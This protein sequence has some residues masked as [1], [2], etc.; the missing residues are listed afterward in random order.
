MPAR[1]LPS[2]RS[3]IS[4]LKASSIALPALRRKLVVGWSD[5]HLRQRAFYS[6][7]PTTFED[8]D[9]FMLTMAN[10]G[11]ARPCLLRVLQACRPVNGSLQ[12][13]IRPILHPSRIQITA[14]YA[15]VAEVGVSQQPQKKKSKKGKPPR[16]RPNRDHNKE[17]G[18]SVMRRTGFRRGT[19]VGSDLPRPI[20][21]AD[22]P[23]VQT[24]PNHGLW[25][26]FYDK[27]KALNTPEED[28][29]HGRAWKVEE[30]RRK[31]WEDLHRLWWVCLKERNRI[32]TGNW[33]RA[34]GEYGY[35]TSESRGREL[36]VCF[37][38]APS[39]ACHR[40]YMHRLSRGILIRD[41]LSTGTKDADCH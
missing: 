18:L 5:V 31:S 33:E 34:K 16:P 14:S 15:S 25:Q 41:W 20:D 35:G 6:R 3:K 37:A 38:A 30:L 39:S 26:F 19:S 40:A 17:R 11:A 23:K 9:Q 13:S 12:P 28:R 4:G 8:I 10:S 22:F 36:E 27:G 7:E 21:E 32:A 2:L 29:E 1:G 24:D